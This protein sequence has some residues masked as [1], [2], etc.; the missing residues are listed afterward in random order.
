MNLNEILNKFNPASYVFLALFLLFCIVQLVLA[1][2]ELEKFRRYEK[3]LCLLS[4][5]IFSIVT[6][7]QSP[8]IYVGCIFGMIGDILVIAFNR[9]Y[10]NFGVLSFLFGHICY[11]CQLIIFVRRSNFEIFQYV[12][13]GVSFVLFY[14]LYFLYTKH[15][16]AKKKEPFGVAL[17]YSSLT[18]FLIFSIIFSLMQG[19][20]S[21]LSIIG[22]SFF[23]I[24]DIIILYTKYNKKFKRYDFYIMLTYL[25]AQTFLVLSLIFSTIEVSL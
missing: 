9:K 18:T 11:A 14:I 12:I 16:S 17:Y 23:V 3:P 22:L 25:I 21:Y 13:L 1:F 8:L 2:L 15:F 6:L 19:G 4:L 24:S 20:L 10:F 5:A 7:P